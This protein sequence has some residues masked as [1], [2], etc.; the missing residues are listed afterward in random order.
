MKNVTLSL[1]EETY[2]R[3]RVLAA[4]RGQSVSALVRE[5]LSQLTT[6]QPDSERELERI[7]AVLD[8]SGVR[9]SAGRRMSRD[10]AH[11]RR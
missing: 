1:D 9:F 3:A 6:P 5:L 8:R 7:F 2:R 10:K 11:E 4:Q